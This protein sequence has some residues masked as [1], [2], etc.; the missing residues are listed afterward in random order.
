MNILIFA[1]S[2]YPFLGGYENFIYNL[3]LKLTKIGYNVHILTMNTENVADIQNLN[4]IYIYRLPC[5][6]LLN[7]TY[8]VPKPTLG[9]ISILRS[10]FS[11][12]YDLIN[13]HT[14]F[15]ITT[16][17]GSIFAKI[18][19]LPHIHV[20]HGSNHSIL[21]NKLIVYANKIYDH[22]IG[23]VV[24]KAAKKNVGISKPSCN[25][26]KHIGAKNP[27]LI[28][29]GVDTT[30]FCRKSSNIRNQLNL[31]GCF[32]L[33]FVGRLVYAK[34]AQ[35]LISIV[36]K[37]KNKRQDSKI[38]IIGDGPYRVELENLVP[39]KYKN[40]VLFLGTKTQ[41]EIVD[42]LNIADIF[43]NL[44][45]SE[46]FGITILEAGAIGLPI[47]ATEVGGVPEL[48]INY[49][50]GFSISPG[51]RTNLF[52]FI[53]K[54][55]E[56]SQLREKLAR[57]IRYKVNKNYNWDTVAEKYDKLFQGCLL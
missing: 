24:V 5:W 46:G 28:L 50:T 16:F 40:D 42:I 2:F 11:N 22:S 9:S 57:N 30:V 45:Y 10:I 47:I 13:T 14:R 15:F 20:E 3:S 55:M 36:P 31:N 32:I 39:K 34:G 53:S 38:I 54:L 48:I 37:I 26:L 21:R 35:D 4:G 41:E 23:W 33:V 17:L 44:S 8:P 49:E 25:F 27:I 1:G 56:D 19:R 29:D 7:R 6:N 18:R 52:Y 51:D 43:V 12:N